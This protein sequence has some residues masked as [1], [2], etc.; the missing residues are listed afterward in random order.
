MVLG[1]LWLNWFS[2]LN[3]NHRLS[4]FSAAAS[5]VAFLLPALFISSPIP[6]GRLVPLW[7]FERLLIA[8]L[9]L[10][11]TTIVI[12]AI[13]NFKF[14][15]L[16]NIYDFRNELEAPR[17]MNYSI[18]ITSN[19]LLPFA[20][21]CFLTRRNFW[22]AGATLILL[23][24]FYP[25]TLSK[26]AFFTPAWL[27]TLACLSKIF[28]VRTTVVLSIFLPVLLGMILI[29]LFKEDALPYFDI[30]N[31][32]LVGVPS[33]AMDMYNDFF[34]DH[35]L[36]Y[37][38]QISVLKPF[39]SCPYQDQLSIVMSKSYHVG[40]FN[41]SL[42]ATEGIA[43]VG[44]LFAPLPVFVCGLI[45]A[46]ANRLSAGLPPRFILISGAILPQVFLNVP[47]TIILVTHGAALLFLLWYITPREMFEQCDVART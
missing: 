14:V 40:N 8:I 2:D 19:A 44:T 27:V 37:F 9:M 3:Y 43:S 11:A 15:A 4:G 47:L 36:T 28:E 1:Y 29:V 5:A 34:S 6:R 38:C 17:I 32:R 24:L 7:A 23:L 39:V 13:Y 10:A 35:D 16:E 18:G 41:A 26:L 30:V 31:F 46:F 33:F 42:F 22:L 25:I 45:I 20:F 21:A 12:S